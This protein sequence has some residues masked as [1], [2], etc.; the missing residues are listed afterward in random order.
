MRERGGCRDGDRGGAAEVDATTTARVQGGNRDLRGP[1]AARAEEGGA[2]GGGTMGCSHGWTM[3]A[4]RCVGV[5]V[6]ASD[7]SDG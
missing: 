3:G 7:A 5:R 6:H 1:P 4:G 2:G